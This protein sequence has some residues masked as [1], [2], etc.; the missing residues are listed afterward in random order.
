MTPPQ[1][2]F[3]DKDSKP[4]RDQLASA[5]G[6]RFAYW[7]E[8]CSYVPGAVVEWKHYGKMIGWTMKLFQKERNLCFMT[9]YQGYF[10]VAF[11]LGDKAVTLAKESA[12]PAEMV[13]ELVNARKYAEGRGIRFDVKSRRALEHAKLLIDIKQG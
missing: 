8:F 3:L 12:L 4:T 13:R 5:L 2:L 10:A 7:E 6:T 11:V 9:A 1:N